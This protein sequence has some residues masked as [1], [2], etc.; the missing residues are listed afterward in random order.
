MSDTPTELGAAH[1]EADDE[2]NLANPRP[3]GLPGVRPFR[4]EGPCSPDVV[5]GQSPVQRRILYAME[6]MGLGYSGPTTIPR[7]AGQS[8]RVVG[9]VLGRYHPHG[10]TAAYDA[11]CA[12]RRT[13]HAALPADRRPGQLRLARRRRRRRMPLH[14]ARLA[15]SLGL[16]DEIDQGTVDFIPNYDGSTEEPAPAAARLPFRAAHS[17]SGIAVGLATEIPSHNLR[18]IADACVALIKTDRCPTTNCSRWCPARTTPAAARSSATADIRDAYR[19][20]RAE[21]ARPLE[22]RGPGARPVAAGG[23][24][25]AA[26]VSNQRVL[27][28]IESSPT[29]KVKTGKKALTPTRPSSRPACWRCWTACATVEQGR[30]SAPGVRAQ[31]APRQ[32]Q[33]LI[34]ALLGHTSLE[35]SAPINLTMVGLDGKPVQKSLRQML[36]GGSVSA[37]PPSRAAA[38]PPPGQGAWTA[39]TSSKAGSWCCSTSTR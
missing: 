33:E 2:F 24:R 8:A 13:F 37:W 20:P 11:W 26:G 25:T 6:R 30:A 19:G 39:S 21:G 38:P 34:T 29:L 36:T 23:Q 27:E 28:E 32:Q 10:D 17:A 22:D 15:R 9:D 1:A 16:L 18:E 4:G 3:A 31:V 7:Q 12:W 5:D 35:T 14:R